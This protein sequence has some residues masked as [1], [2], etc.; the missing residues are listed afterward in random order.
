MKEK[1]EFKIIECSG[2]FYEIGKQYG[3]ACRDN[4]VSSIN[5]VFRDIGM[6]QKASKEDIIVTAKKYLP[7]V[8]RFDPELLEMLKGQ[9]DGAGV[10][11]DEVFTLRCK[12]ELG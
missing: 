7:L 4:L 10:T 2:S 12:L 8:E 6:F 11:F 3:I 5:S 9:A 1:K